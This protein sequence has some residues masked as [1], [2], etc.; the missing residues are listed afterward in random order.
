MQCPFP[1]TITY[2]TKVRPDQVVTYSSH[3]TISKETGTFHRT[4]SVPCGKCIVCQ[5]KR[6]SEWVFRIKEESK[7]HPANSCWFLTLTY[8]KDSLPLDR[9]G[10]GVLKYSDV[11]LFI[12]CLRQQL[13]RKYGLR[14]RFVCV[15]EYGYNGTERPH[16]HLI[17]F[18]L[19]LSFGTLALCFKQIWSKGRISLS[20]LTSGRI[21][22]VAKYSF[23]SSLLHKSVPPF[24]RCSLRPA[25][26][27]GYLSDRTVNYVR[28]NNLRSVFLGT[29]KQNRP[30]YIPLPRYY[31][32]VI[33]EREQN[34][35]DRF[36][37]FPY[38]ELPPQSVGTNSFSEFKF[39]SIFPSF[40]LSTQ[41]VRRLR[42]ILLDS[43]RRD[44]LS[45]TDFRFGFNIPRAYVERA[46][47]AYQVLVKSHLKRDSKQHIKF[48]FN[49]WLLY[50][51]PPRLRDRAKIPLIC[52]TPPTIPLSSAVLLR[53]TSW[54][55]FRAI[56]FEDPVNV[57]CA[58]L[59]C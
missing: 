51:L 4:V 57:L 46:R 10:D 38:D 20:A 37:Q 14:F 45:G 6:Q 36:Y 53:Q 52:R 55:A 3:D 28:N 21:S 39:G 18:G 35:I 26:G 2:D 48:N 24:L 47:A 50:S 17:L 1:I 25:I 59:Q 32:R 44:R 5:Q 7:C 22:Y 15:G 33:Y 49:T 27:F 19:P 42:R 54:N 9:N 23:G 8:D 12:K 58:S 30:I 56:F 11:Q 13:Y 43:F 31:K 40:C 16:Y 34:E 41:N 29:S